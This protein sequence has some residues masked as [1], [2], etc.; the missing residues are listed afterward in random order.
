[1]EA[2]KGHQSRWRWLALSTR[3]SLWTAP[4]ALLASGLAFRLLGWWSAILYLTLLVTGLRLNTVTVG[5]EEVCV[6]KA[7]FGGKA[8]VP[9]SEIAGYMI[10]EMGGQLVPL[11]G[12]RFVTCRH[13]PAL[14]V[15]LP[16]TTRKRQEVLAALE[17]ELR[18]KSVLRI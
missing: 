15:V 18:C 5:D 8:K 1:M 9:L 7:P 10:S 14:F 17:A 12:I 6:E 4:A 13:Q 3:W 2:S 16:A 11:Q